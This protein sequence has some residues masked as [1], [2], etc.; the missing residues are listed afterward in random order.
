MSEYTQDELAALSPEER[1]ALGVDDEEK[2]ALGEI[3]E[4]TKDAA[5]EEGGDAADSDS[6][7]DEADDK[8]EATSEKGDGE[9][10]AE[11]TKDEAQAADEEDE[12]FIPVYQA[13]KVENYDE[14]VKALAAERS[15]VLA[16]FKNG[17]L[18]ASDMDEQLEAIDS[19]RRDLDAAKTKADISEEQAAQTAHQKWQWEIGRFMR[20][21]KEHDGVD[22]AQDTIMHAALDAQVKALGA[23][24]KHADKPQAWFLNEAHRLLRAKF[25]AADAATDTGKADKGAKPKIPSRKPDLRR[26]PT[27]VA[28]LPGAGT[29]EGGGDGEFAHLSKL[30]GIELEAAVAS[31][32]PAQQDRWYREGQ[33]A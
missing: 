8:Q 18:E 9:Q 20:R 3:V 24:P 5:G 16:K 29:D 27:S 25:G 17:E 22:Y 7:D 12:Q 28:Q 11:G 4:E 32:S 23:D 6:E 30:S 19:K 10:D 21:A 1:A 13:P 2:D 26:V 15:A 31:M 14:Q 33:A